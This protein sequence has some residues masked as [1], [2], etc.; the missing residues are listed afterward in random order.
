MI[1]LRST[2]ST[3]RG[4]PG[5]RAMDF[6]PGEGDLEGKVVLTVQLGNIFVAGEPGS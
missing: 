5:H 4:T 2:F 1:L 3:A 6:A